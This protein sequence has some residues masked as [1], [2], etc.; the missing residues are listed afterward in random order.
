VLK[1]THSLTG[2]SAH[3]EEKADKAQGEQQS[4]ESSSSSSSNAQWRH[5]VAFF[6]QVRVLVFVCACVL[7][8]WLNVEFLTRT[9]FPVQMGNGFEK[10]VEEQ[11]SNENKGWV[12]KAN[13]SPRYRNP[14]D[15]ERRYKRVAREE[16]ETLELRRARD[17]VRAKLRAKLGDK[18]A[19]RAELR[20]TDKRN[21]ERDEVEE[22][23]K[24]SDRSSADDNDAGSDSDGDEDDDD[25]DDE[26]RRMKA[27]SKR[28]H[29]VLTE[30]AVL[31]RGQGTKDGLALVTEDTAELELYSNLK[32][33]ME[34]QQHTL[35][36][37]DSAIL[38]TIEITST[39]PRSG[40]NEHAMWVKQMYDAGQ[41]ESG[42]E[43]VLPPG[44]LANR[45]RSGTMDFYHLMNQGAKLIVPTP[46]DEE[47][48]EVQ[49]EG[50]DGEDEG[51]ENE[52]RWAR[53]RWD[54]G[55]EARL[56]L[57]RDVIRL[58]SDD[59]VVDRVA[60]FGTHVA[61]PMEAVA[62][63]LA[64]S[65]ASPK[66]VGYLHLVSPSWAQLLGQ[67]AGDAVW[68]LWYKQHFG[69]GPFI[70]CNRTYL[71][72]DRVLWQW[73]LRIMRANQSSGAAREY[74]LSWRAT[75]KREWASLK[76]RQ[77]AES[78]T[79]D[80]AFNMLLHFI[81]RGHVVLVRVRMGFLSGLCPGKR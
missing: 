20:A 76:S 70:T 22:W 73:A 64:S 36:Q 7:V 1:L 15:L 69:G 74:P 23:E 38:P 32:R 27:R 80:P 39:V 71:T 25:D 57:V 8:S 72:H 63:I 48:N 3:A 18:L 29:L 77:R 5:S 10:M 60:I 56:E 17:R 2:S 26:V 53:R 44:A 37:S 13:A 41:A 34:Q 55:F 40:S 65:C 67:A 24:G 81:Y 51:N 42:D 52:D 49:N 75:Y 46:E 68:A 54:D 12:H 62:L 66:D 43:R 35:S 16:E 21:G 58:R 59:K 28:V 78:R 79:E 9:L 50:S 14:E 11:K 45:G 33:G 30:C 47:N 4:A 19:K 61:L 31:T 6:S